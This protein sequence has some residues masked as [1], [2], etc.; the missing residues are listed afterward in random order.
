MPDLAA[1]FRRP[2]PGSRPSGSGSGTSCPPRAGARRQLH[3]E[4]GRHPQEIGALLKS[5][6]FLAVGRSTDDIWPRMGHRDCLCNS[7]RIHPSPGDSGRNLRQ[8][9]QKIR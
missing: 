2:F 4:L 5:Q 6:K 3:L 7:L 9:A 1:I 8:V